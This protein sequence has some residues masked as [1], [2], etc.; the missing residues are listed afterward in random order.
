MSTGSMISTTGFDRALYMDKS[1]VQRKLE[2]LKAATRNIKRSVRICRASVSGSVWRDAFEPVDKNSCYRLSEK[3]Q[4]LDIQYT[5]QSMLL[6]QDYMDYSTTSF[7][8]IAFPIPE[9]GSRFEEI[10][11]ETIKVN[12]LDVALYTRIQQTIIDTLD[13]GEFVRILGK[14]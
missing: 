4:K 2:V 7:T 9:I 5:T 6:S 10:F 11:E 14:G 8:I 12:T 3:Q 1:L 13:Q